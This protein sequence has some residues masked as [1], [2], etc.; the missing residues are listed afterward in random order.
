MTELT[1][2]TGFAGEWIRPIDPGYDDA[3]RVW[4]AAIDRRPALVA[5]PAAT[6]DVALAVRYAR[7]R[8]LPIAVRGGGHSPAGHSTGD[9]AVV[10]DLRSLGE[11]E[12]DAR[13][14]TA[15]VG[16][17]TLLSA[18]DKAGQAHGLVV[19]VGVIGHTGVGGLTLGGGMGRLQNKF[20][21]TI[22][23]LQA[24]EVV[25][26]D[27]SIVTA[28]SDEHP[29]LFWAIRGAGHNF[30]VVTRFEFR[31]RPFDGKLNRSVRLYDGRYVHD[32]WAMAAQLAETVPDEVSFTFGIGRAVPESDYPDD[33]AGRPMA[34]V[35]V[36]HCGDAADVERDTAALLGGPAPFNTL[37]GQVDYVTIQTAND[38]AMAWGKRSYID[39][40]F[41]NGLSAGTLDAAVQHVASAPGEAGIGLARFGGAVRRVAEDATA[42]PSRTAAFEMSADAG[43]WDDAADDDRYIGW[44]REAMAILARDACPGRYVNEI[45]DDGDGVARSIYGDAKY[46]QLARLKRAWDPDNVF[47][48][49]QNIEP[50]AG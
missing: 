41:T 14:R 49:N 28:S 20:G 43:A 40:L 12:V 47:R 23:N 15:R 10:I 16:G 27:G 44:C 9:G 48:S 13:R 31:L 19:P 8:H 3:R 36:N 33:V 1:A 7:E 32:V 37:S 17:G 45:S 18:L 24:V 26:A 38:E 21:L 5:R 11:V 30:G 42:F 35:A 46:D 4:N 50:A 34:F 25:L 29:D 2:P 22:D 6:P 39:G